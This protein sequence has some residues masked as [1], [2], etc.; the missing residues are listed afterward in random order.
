MDSLVRHLFFAAS[1]GGGL[2]DLPTDLADINLIERDWCLG[3]GAAS[4]FR[5]RVPT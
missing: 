5:S 2:I 4:A 3:A 1:M